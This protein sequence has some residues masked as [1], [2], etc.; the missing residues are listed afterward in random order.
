MR[1]LRVISFMM[2]EIV[3]EQLRTG[4]CEMLSLRSVEA[5]VHV[6]SNLN[7]DVMGVSF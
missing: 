2:S 1:E 3:A 6:T 4:Q 5:L 7:C